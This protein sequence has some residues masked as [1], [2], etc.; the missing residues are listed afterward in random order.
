MYYTY[1]LC[2]NIFILTLKIKEG[3]CN[4]STGPDTSLI[5][6]P[7]PLYEGTVNI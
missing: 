4:G 1:I 6:G 2:M 3:L 7:E 5:P